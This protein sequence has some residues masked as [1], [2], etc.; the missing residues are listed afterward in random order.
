MPG[1]DLA[2]AFVEIDRLA[3][4]GEAGKAEGVYAAILPLLTYEAQSLEL[5]IVGAKLALQANGMFP[6]ARIRVP[7]FALDAEQVAT[8]NRLFDRLREEGVAGWC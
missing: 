7:G 1:C 8:F 4:E 3:R 6:T 2:P 5:L